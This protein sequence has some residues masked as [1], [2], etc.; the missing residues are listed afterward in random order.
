MKRILL[1]L[2]VSAVVAAMMAI[3]PSNAFA[4][5]LCYLDPNTGE[6]VCGCVPGTNCDEQP[7]GEPVPCPVPN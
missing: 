6:P 4:S 7:P 1:L 3:T 5:E 2:T